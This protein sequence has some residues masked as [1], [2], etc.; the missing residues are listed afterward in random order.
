VC[1]CKDQFLLEL[2]QLTVVMILAHFVQDSFIYQFGYGPL[3][4]S[5]LDPSIGVNITT[6]MQSHVQQLP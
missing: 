2:Q 4:A 1:S 3:A 5:L 6:G